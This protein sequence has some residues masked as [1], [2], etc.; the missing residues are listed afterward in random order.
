M[1]NK[2]MWGM[3]VV[4]MP[5]KTFR[6][7]PDLCP[8]FNAD[9]D[10][11]E[12]NITVPGSSESAAEV[13][14][15][16]SLPDGLLN[17]AN[18]KPSIGAHQ[19]VL[20]GI[21]LMTQ[22]GTAPLTRSEARR[23]ASAA[24]WPPGC[25]WRTGTDAMRAALIPLGPAFAWGSAGVSVAHGALV[26]G[27]LTAAHIGSAAGGLL[28]C[29]ARTRGG[30]AALRMLDTLSDLAHAYLRMRP[31]AMNGEDLL[32]GSLDTPDVGAEPGATDEAVIQRLHRMRVGDRIAAGASNAFTLMAETGIKGGRTNL[33]QMYGAIGQQTVSGILFHTH[34]YDY[35]YP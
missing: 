1:S 34:A 13:R 6:F 28:H 18:S 12:M 11:D 9:Y 32:L 21:M 2:S 27:P 24:K 10:G 31:T 16:A 33:N 5:G 23:L 20:M 8:P 7:H 4:R 15:I 30:H 29:V 14:R 22:P 35:T 19:D 26:G 3:E 25:A 17:E